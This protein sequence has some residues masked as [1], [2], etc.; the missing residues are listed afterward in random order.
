MKTFI[1]LGFLFLIFSNINGQSLEKN[2][3]Q[4]SIG[5]NLSVPFIEEIKYYPGHHNYLREYKAS[6]GYNVAIAY[7]IKINKRFY[8]SPEIYYYQ[9]RLNINDEIFFVTTYLGAASGNITTRYIGFENTIKYKIFNEGPLSI[10]C[11]YYFGILLEAIERRHGYYERT[12]S[13]KENIIP[14]DYGIEPQLEC[15]LISNS[16][17]SLLLLSKFNI[18]L[19]S[20]NPLSIDENEKKWKNYNFKLGLGIRF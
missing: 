15:D 14:I 19:I 11:G 5:L 7:N 12:E 13:I 17:F 9:S 2:N 4:I 3:F 8:A 16:K 1:S 20:V 18:G 10:G 6:L